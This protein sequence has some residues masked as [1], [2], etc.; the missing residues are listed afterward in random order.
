MTSR[1]AT[2]SPLVSH[3]SSAPSALMRAAML[4]ILLVAFALRAWRLD[5]QSF[6]SDEGLSLNRAN[7]PLA[8]MLARMPVEHVPGYFV[9]LR[10]WLMLTGTHDYGMRAFSLLPSVLAVALCFRLAADAAAPA[11]PRFVIGATAALLAAVSPFLIW[12]AQ[13]TRMYAWLLAAALAATIS[14]WRV[15][16]ARTAA[17]RRYATIAYALCTAATVYLHWF[18]AFV[19]MAHTL[20]VAG[21]V[22]AGWL[23]GTRGEALWSGPLA[24]LVGSSGA[25]LLFLPWLPRLTG[26]L[27]FSGWREDGSVAEIPWRYLQAYAGRSDL[28][29]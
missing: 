15:L 8:E 9:A 5:Y 6:W 25:L 11:R 2:P 1:L 19:P 4:L 12:Y 13:E 17:E 22:L 16:F 26:V 20:F 10:G 18:G 27:G 14:L 7:L 29:P 3:R 24:W 28:A 23:T 21:F